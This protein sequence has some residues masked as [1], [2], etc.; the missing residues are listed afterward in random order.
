MPVHIRHKVK[1][2]AQCHEVLQRQHGHL[3]PQ[4][5]A[6]NA[7][8]HHVGDL[9]IGADLLGIGQHGL[10]G[11][12]HQL[13]RRGQIT[14]QGAFGLAQQPMHHGAAL[15]VV[16]RLAPEHGIAVRGQASLAGQF[17]QQGFSGDVGMIF[18]QVGKHMGG[19]LAQGRCPLGILRKRGAQI[20]TRGQCR[21]GRQS[22]PGRCLVTTHED[23][24]AGKRLSKSRSF[25][26]EPTPVGDSGE[27]RSRVIAHGVRS[28][29]ERC[30]AFFINSSSFTASAQKARMPSASFSVAM[31]S[32]L[33]ANRKE[34][35]S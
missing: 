10:E 24:Q 25:L 20:K 9:R 21:M 34:A 33:S 26:S 18:G 31:A 13:Q 5:R 1:S 19:G 7:D 12:V 28:Y 16:D 3:R 6:A 14:A 27:R 11:V 35:S 4:V 32:S 8:V 23:F 22:L 15:G 30:Q 2:L 29:V 17:D